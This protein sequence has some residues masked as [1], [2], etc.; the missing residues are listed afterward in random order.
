MIQY[1]RFYSQHPQSNGHTVLESDHGDVEAAC[2]SCCSVGPDPTVGGQHHHCHLTQ[3]G[4]CTDEGGLTTNIA[5]PHPREV[6]VEVL[7]RITVSSLLYRE[8]Y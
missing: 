7:R 1:K 4:T 8:V 6:H 2:Y 3:Q 5:L